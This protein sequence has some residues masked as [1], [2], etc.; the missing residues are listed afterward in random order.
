MEKMEIGVMLAVGTDPRDGLRKVMELGL[1]CCQLGSPGDEWLESPRREEVK[2]AIEEAGVRVTTVFVGFEGES[3]ADIETVKRTVGFGERGTR[4][5]RLARAERVSEFAKF[6][7]VKR[8]ASHIGFIPEDAR[9]KGYRELAEAVRRLADCCARN[10]QVFALET[11]QEPAEVL[12]GFIEDVGCANVRVNFDPA[13]MILYGSGE[14]LAALEM[15]KGYVD[16]VHV[17]DGD[18]PTE[19]GKLGQERRLGEGK[20]NIPGFIA[21]LKEIGYTGPLT[22]EREISGAEQM[23]DIRKGIDWLK[24]LRQG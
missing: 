16:G 10:G 21:K 8:V 13:N 11:G 24:E 23:R 6:L 7:G 17:K 19:K 15:L 22:I 4:A 18:W 14:P 2:R 9:E 3:Y 5:R 1:K 20:V 12:K